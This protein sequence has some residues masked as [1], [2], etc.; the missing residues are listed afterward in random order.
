MD[1]SRQTTTPLGTATT[2]QTGRFSIMPAAGA[3]NQQ[4]LPDL[5]FNVYDVD[6]K[7]LL[8]NTDD[9]V[10]WNS[11]TQEDVTIYLY[12]QVQTTMGKDRI[13]SSQAI[14]AT[15]FVR[16]SD[17]SGLFSQT[18]SS[19]GT[20]FS[21]V[22]DMLS[23]SISKINLKPISVPVKTAH[24]VNT[25]VETA[26]RNLK[27]QNVTVNQVMTYNPAVNKD[28]LTAIGGFTPVLKPGQ[29]V[30]LYQ[31]NGQVKYYS[32]VKTGASAPAPPPA[33]APPAPASPPHASVPTS[34]PQV[35]P[36]LQPV[37]TTT[38]V[39]S[40]MPVSGA[41]I[42]APVQPVDL[43]GLQAELAESKAAAAQKDQQIT[44]LMQD[45]DALRKDQ[46]EIR[47][48]LKSKFPS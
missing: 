29:T 2:D 35:I 45:L 33:A 19:I 22:T 21:F 25:D 15:N 10:V 5:Y 6:G 27:D 24:V 28:A 37:Y 11:G 16:K 1:S 43:A 20:N 41:H 44:Q 13:N 12:T 18:K 48:L 8:T 46:D 36:P 38:P 17:F 23:N 7:T 34:P 14:N 32:V 31:V 9:Y 26:T 47:A 42:V 3:N 39:V 30:N 40:N 4:T